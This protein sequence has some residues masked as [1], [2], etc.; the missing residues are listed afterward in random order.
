MVDEDEDKTGPNMT[1]IQVEDCTEMTSKSENYLW[2]REQS[3]SGEISDETTWRIKLETLTHK[4]HWESG[5]GSDWSPSTPLN[6]G[7]EGDL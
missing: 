4:I 3:T 1:T 7:C 2:W 5:I 6:L